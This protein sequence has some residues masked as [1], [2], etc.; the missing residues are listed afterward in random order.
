MLRRQLAGLT[1]ATLTV[2]TLFCALSLGIAGPQDKEKGQPP[3][4]EAAKEKAKSAPPSPEGGAAKEKA[5]S[6]PPSPEG[7]AAKREA[8]IT[9]MLDEFD[10]KPHP[11]P[12]IPDD[13]PPHEGAMISIPHVVEPPDLILVEVLE[14]LPGRPVSGERLVRPDGK[15]SIGFYGEVDVRGLTLDQVKVAIIKQMRKYLDDDILGLQTPVDEPQ[16]VRPLI[17]ELPA[18]EGKPLDLEPQRKEESKTRSTSTKTH[19][20]PHLLRGAHTASRP[21]AGVRAF[22][23]SSRSRIVRVSTQD[24]PA[25]APNMVVVPVGPQGKVTITFEV[26]GRNAI[27]VQPARPVPM[28]EEVPNVTDADDGSWTIV[29][30]AQSQSV[31]VDITAY[32]SKNYYI[33][34]DVLIPGKLPLT[35]NETVLDAL[36]FAGGLMPTADPKD[37]RLVRPSHHGKP[38]KVYKVDLAAIQERGDVTSNYQIFPDDRLIVGRDEVVK[39]TVAMDRLAAPIQTATSSIHSVANMLRA[40]QL[41]DQANSGAILKELVDFWAKEAAR[42]G[43]VTFDPDKL[44]EALLQKLKPVAIPNK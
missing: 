13:P 10:L 33:L 44:R 7:G 2:L 26:H 28:P 23:G 34:G 14:A 30:P 41:A 5:K 31:F 19:P 11:L 8:Q 39:K 40:I 36:Q 22:S 16:T 35:G 12:S 29:S 20:F 42:N 17:P 24:Q 25:P 38:A 4:G 9:K 3:T 27:A 21:G 1:V 15:I 18:G 32:N 37:I 43:D 6:V